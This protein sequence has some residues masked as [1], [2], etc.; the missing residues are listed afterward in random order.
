MFHR[1]SSAPS[2]RMR[3]LT[4]FLLVLCFCLSLVP[5]LRAQASGKIEGT[6]VDSSQAVVP[7]ARLTCKN[8]DTGLVRTVETNAAGI[9]AFPDLPIG[10]YTLAVSRQGFKALNTNPMQ[11]LTGQELNLPLVQIGRAD[12]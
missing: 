10:Q 12:V 7:G 11:L 2:A 4:T 5:S 1:S 8:V 6:V 9:F 3:S